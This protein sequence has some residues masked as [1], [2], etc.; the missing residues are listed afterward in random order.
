MTT[1][2]MTILTDIFTNILVRQD[3]FNDQWKEYV[4]QSDFSELLTQMYLLNDGENI[5]PISSKP[6][7]IN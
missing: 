4:Y 7:G 5:I 6:V 1:F 3:W 2:Q